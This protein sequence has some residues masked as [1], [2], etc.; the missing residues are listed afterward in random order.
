VFEGA[1]QLL[2]SVQ[3]LASFVISV[4]ATSADADSLR[5]S[6]RAECQRARNRDHYSVPFLSI[7]QISGIRGDRPETGEDLFRRLA[8]QPQVHRVRTDVDVRSPLDRSVRSKPNRVEKRCVVP[9]LE[10][11]T[12]G[13]VGE[14]DIPLGSVI[15]SE[16]IRKFG[17]A[18]TWIGRAMIKLPR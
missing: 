17:S 13:Q 3:A 12:P 8:R 11:T 2:D 4:A 6:R 15:V 7:C 16:P 9:S 10:H 1:T 5:H 14:V 18:L